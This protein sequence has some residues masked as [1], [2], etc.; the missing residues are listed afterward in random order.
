MNL[1]QREIGKLRSG[2]LVLLC[3]KADIL[4]VILLALAAVRRYVKGHEPSPNGLLSPVGASAS[5]SG[6]FDP[7]SRACGSRC[8]DRELH[9]GP[10]ATDRA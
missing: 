4:T 7:G 3:Y 2:V 6:R 10:H 5:R 8:T 1:S 9:Q